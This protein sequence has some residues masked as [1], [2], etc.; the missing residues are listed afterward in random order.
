MEAIAALSLACNILQVAE[1]SLKVTKTFRQAYKH[2]SVKETEDVIRLSD[3]MSSAV[4][5]LE[6]SMQRPFTKDDAELNQ[7]A[8]L[9]LDKATRLRDMNV[10]DPKPTSS[11]RTRD[12][13]KRGFR[14]VRVSLNG[15]VKD[16][17]AEIQTLREDLD[18]RIL[19]SLR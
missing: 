4:T 17:E 1:L 11:T 10:L 15:E 9:C 12:R 3:N 5:E 6:S 7:I 8:Q 2:D 19:V 16:L 14:V 13:L 18:T